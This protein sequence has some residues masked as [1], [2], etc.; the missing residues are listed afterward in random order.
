MRLRKRKGQSTVEYLIIFAI[1]IAIV[2]GVAGL[3]FKP[4]IEDIFNRAA[5]RPSTVVNEDWLPK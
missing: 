2:V 3:V 5:K 1:I 4:H